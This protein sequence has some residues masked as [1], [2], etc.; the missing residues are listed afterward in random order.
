M[1][2]SSLRAAVIA[3]MVA[4]TMAGA[5]WAASAQQIVREGAMAK[6]V[7]D[8]GEDVSPWAVAEATVTADT[9]HVKQ[10]ETAM[11]LAIP[12]DHHAGQPDYP[13]GWP[14]TYRDFTEPWEQDWSSFEFFSFWIYCATSREALPQTPLGLILYTPDK[15][16]Q[17]NR[18]IAE[19]AK[20]NWVHIVIPLNQIPRHERVT[21]IQFYISESGYSHGDTLDIYVDDIALTRYAEPTIDAFSVG[22]KAIWSDA[23]WL[24]ATFRMLGLQA[25]G[26]AVV[27]FEVRRG[28][29]V[30]ATA[31]RSAAQ[32][33]QQVW[34]DL[35]GKPLPP[36]SCEVAARLKGARDWVTAPVM[37]VASPWEGAGK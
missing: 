23:R 37:V 32:G 1:Q 28:R 25:G 22:Q 3:A 12:V 20:D 19:L 33:T 24:P 35:G 16:R 17:H 27:E 6:L 15:P 9:A 10:G 2:V 7:L 26:E 4:A 13:I 36:G 18:T 34:I 11:H 31:T 29:R 30:A 5:P 21:R 8:G 14:R